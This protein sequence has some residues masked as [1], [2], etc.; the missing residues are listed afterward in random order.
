MISAN[1]YA[2]KGII[3]N[4]LYLGFPKLENE[5]AEIVIKWE[6]RPKITESDIQIVMMQ[7]TGF[8]YED[9]KECLEKFDGDLVNAIIYFQ[10]FHLNNK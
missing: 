4:D 1:R 3:P 9:C 2:Q 7:T 8:S 6:E 10:D 5:Q